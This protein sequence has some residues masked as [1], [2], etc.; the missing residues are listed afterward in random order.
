[1]ETPLDPTAPKWAAAPPGGDLAPPRLLVVD[2]DPVNRAVVASYF[3]DTYEVLQAD[4]GRRALELCRGNPPDILLL[5]IVMPGMD[6]LEVCRT[7]KED[8]D[9]RDLPVIFITTLGTPHEETQALEAGGVDFIAKP[10]NPAVVRARVRTHLTLKRQ[11]DLLRS[12]A[13][14]DGLTGIANRRRFDEYLGTEWRR[15]LRN[16]APFS[17]LMADI[18]LFKHYNDHFGHPAGDAC[19]QRVAR[20]LAAALRRPQD[21]LTR[22]GGEEFACLLPETDRP[23]A[24][25]VGEAMLQAVRTLQLPHEGVGPG[26]VTVSMGLAT[27]VPGPGS[28]PDALVALADRELYQAKAEGRNRLLG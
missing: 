1:M 17:L 27:L 20:A 23:G 22:Y 5:D 4:S 12:L 11:S 19:L 18:D 25:V 7:L 13:F 15:G 2:D 10:V 26:F 14:L 8:P 21:L 16:Q 24:R 28:S 6:G 3:E 9:L